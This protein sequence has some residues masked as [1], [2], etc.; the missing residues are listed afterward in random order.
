[1]GTE[2]A[3]G[4]TVI[5]PQWPN[6]PG[7][8]CP[9][10]VPRVGG[11]VFISYRHEVD[12]RYVEADVTLDFIDA[13]VGVTASITLRSPMRC[14]V[15]LGESRLLS[16]ADRTLIEEEIRKRAPAAGG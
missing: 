2:P 6:A 7:L 3:R 4:V 11:H 12:D 1:M 5:D 16:P 8:G 10:I 13:A 9:D 15:C 14:D